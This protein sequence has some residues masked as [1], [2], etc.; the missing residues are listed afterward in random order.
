[1]KFAFVNGRVAVVVRYWEERNPVVD[2]GCRVEVREVTQVEGREHRAGNAGFTVS[3]VAPG[4][5]WRADLFVVLTE[6]GAPCF[7]FHPEFELDD[8]GERFWD[9]D[10]AADPRAWIAA[11]LGD[12]PGLLRRAGGAQLLASVDLAEHRAALPLM[13]AAVDACLARIPAA[14][15]VH[16]P[17]PTY[18]AT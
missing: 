13:L 1:M 14:L 16:N 18:V 12:L 10:L 8:V 4:G 5:R 11:H 2:G 6:N 17:R 7:H 3:P 9:D 15:A